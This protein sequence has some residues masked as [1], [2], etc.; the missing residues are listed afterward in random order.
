VVVETA[1]LGTD[2]TEPDQRDCVATAGE[3]GTE[4]IEPLYQPLR[5]AKANHANS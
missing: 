3:H 1:Q 5:D 4:V 2:R